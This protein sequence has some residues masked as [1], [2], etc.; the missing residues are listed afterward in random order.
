MTYAVDGIHQEI[1]YVAHHLHWSLE[2]IMDLEHHD[3]RR[4]VAAAG[5]LIETAGEPR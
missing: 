4:Y 5:R 3:R 1:A 2:D